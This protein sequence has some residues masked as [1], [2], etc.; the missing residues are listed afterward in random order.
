VLVDQREELARRR[1][2][3]LQIGDVDGVGGLLRLFL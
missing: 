2:D 1:L 3:L